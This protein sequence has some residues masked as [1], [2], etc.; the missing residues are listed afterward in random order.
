MEENGNLTAIGNGSVLPP[1]VTDGQVATIPVTQDTM[2]TLRQNR[3]GCYF[4]RVQVA[5]FTVAF[6]LSI[7]LVVLLLTFVRKEQIIHVS[8]PGALQTCNQEINYTTS[9][10]SVESDSVQ[11]ETSSV[12]AENLTRVENATDNTT[13]PEKVNITEV[14]V[15]VRKERPWDKIRL[16]RDILPERYDIF[17]RIDLDNRTFKGN[18]NI[19]V[20]TSA[21]KKVLLLH[22]NILW[23]VKDSVKVRSLDGSKMYKIKLQFQVWKTQFWVIILEEE[24]KLS[25]YYVIEIG[26]FKGTMYT[27]LR[28][29]YLS[30][31]ES[32]TGTRYLAATQ[33]QSTDAR[34]VF[35]CFDEPDM[36]A[37]FKLT[38]QHEEGYTALSNMPVESEQYLS[39]EPGWLRVNFHETPI[40]STY[41]LA[42]VVSDFVYK[43]AILDGNYQLRIWSQPNKINQ[44]LYALDIG[45]QLYDYFT[46]YFQITDVVPKADHVAVPDFSG[47]AMENWGL[48]IYRETALLFDPDVSSS[49][50]QLMVTLIIAHEIAHTWFGNMVTMR[51]WDDLWLNE[52][53]ASLLMYFAMDHVFPE[54]EVFT[55]HVVVKEVFPVMVRDALT[56]SHPVSTPILT[57]DDITQSFDAISYSKGM[58]VLRMLLG[59]VGWE[60]FRTG[61]QVYVTRYKFK[62]AVMEQLWQTFS[63]AVE[64]KFVIG[65]IMDTWTRQ[66]G[67]PVVTLRSDGDH[68]ILDQDRFLLDGNS[69]M[70]DPSPYEYKWHIPFTYVTEAEPDINN[71]KIVWLNMDSA[72]IPKGENQWILGNVDYIGFYRVNYELSMWRSLAEQLNEDHTVFAEANRAGLIGDAFNLARAK[73][74]DYDVAFNMTTYL[75]KEERYVPWEAML[76][77]I[78]F[79]KGMLSKQGAY[80]LL[81]QYLH[82]LVAPVYDKVGTS[83]GGILP[84]KYLREVILTTACDVGVTKAIDYAK[85]KFRQWKEDGV[86]PP[87]HF[88]LTIY[89]VGVREGSVEEWDHVWNRSQVSNVAAERQMLMEALAQTQKP[90]LLWRYANWIFDETKIKRQD[91]RLVVS[92]FAKN[93]LG[94]M[95]ALHL[96]MNKWEQLNEQFGADGF[97]L[98][99]TIAEVTQFVNT[100]F[101]LDQLATLFSAKMPAVAFRETRNS[102]ELIRGN[103]KWM[104]ANYQTISDWLRL[105]VVGML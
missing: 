25:G 104:K 21:P 20:K 91:V 73:L 6:A 65:E 76:E 34:K 100:E 15:P 41:L 19:T 87:S 70:G 92:Y 55:L 85:E 46:N 56:T 35:P 101:E 4:T 58:A 13:I 3:K 2:V 90:W 95:I 81:R 83:P 68:Y 67:Y 82:D 89:S 8:S 27:D 47:G 30:S 77:S 9:S 86:Q 1:G 53:F 54:W 88:S 60:E 14:M 51:W 44:T 84:E 94:R 52:G 22:I 5:I 105:H 50:N 61:L 16:P 10:I 63:E 26:T 99:E 79:I 43:E 23:I 29:L 66:M 32:S 31:Y 57:P 42:I 7:I 18:V 24:L 93:P 37:T 69:S 72:R 59:F 17:L 49:E 39:T 33:L 64:N 38:I 74:L 98:R 103:I 75:N 78:R 40:M 102:L 62:N 28:G 36:K 96:L 97:L 12:S 71:R 45:I 80:I 48:V 11:N